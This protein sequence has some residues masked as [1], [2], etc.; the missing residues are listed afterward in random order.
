M[1]IRLRLFDALPN[2]GSRIDQAAQDPMTAI[3][4]TGSGLA[5]E[6]EDHRREVPEPDD[7]IRTGL[8]WGM[9]WLIGTVFLTMGMLLLRATRTSIDRERAHAANCLSSFSGRVPC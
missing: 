4:P 9:I 2:T 6:V 5:G 8:S 7:L 1:R 3:E